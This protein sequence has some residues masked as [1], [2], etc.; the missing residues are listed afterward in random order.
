MAHVAIGMHECSEGDAYRPTT[1]RRPGSA[2]GGLSRASCGRCP[3]RGMPVTPAP[4]FPKR[5]TR[6]RGRSRRRCARGSP[7]QSAGRDHRSRSLMEVLGFDRRRIRVPVCTPGRRIGIRLGRR[8]ARAA[9]QMPRGT[10]PSPTPPPAM[11]PRWRLGYGA[12]NGHRAVVV[13]GRPHEVGGPVSTAS[14]RTRPG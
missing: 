4:G 1:G 11:S 7:F 8:R 5:E 14:W 3:I 6:R 9:E 12:S 2:A 10:N 13:Q